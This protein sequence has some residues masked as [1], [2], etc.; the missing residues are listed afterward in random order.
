MCMVYVH[1]FQF[2]TFLPSSTDCMYIT[3]I[4]VFL[5]LFLSNSLFS[6][7]FHSLHNSF[8]HIPCIC[9]TFVSKFTTHLVA[10]IL[11]CVSLLFCLSLLLLLVFFRV[12]K[13]ASQPTPL[14][15]LRWSWG[16]SSWARRERLVPNS[17][18]GKIWI[19]QIQISSSTSSLHS[20]LSSLPLLS[21]TPSTYHP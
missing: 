2:F 8:S 6:F 18:N 7:N 20:S 3:C 4:F 5:S 13:V 11:P 16:S 15:C 10:S 14:W 12:S 9:F 21:H 19:L 17:N 1:S